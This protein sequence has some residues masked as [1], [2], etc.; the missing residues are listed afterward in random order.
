MASV[1]QTRP[2]CVNQMEKTHSERLAARHGR[3]TAWARN[4]NGMLCVNRPLF[5][6]TRYFC[7]PHSQK[8]GEGGLNYVSGH[9]VGTRR[10]MQRDSKAVSKIISRAWIE[11][12]GA[13]FK[14]SRSGDK[15]GDLFQL[16]VR[17]SFSV[18]SHGVERLQSLKPRYITD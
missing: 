3:G 14:S 13:S 1:N 9:Y 4:G 5:R 16:L 18:L 17:G 10:P 6:H 7:M 8:S 12:V 15:Q 2:H 11:R